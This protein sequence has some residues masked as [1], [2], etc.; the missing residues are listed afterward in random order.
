MAASSS[1]RAFTGSMWSNRPRGDLASRSDR[2][3]LPFA[4]S[5][6][7]VRGVATTSQFPSLRD[8]RTHDLVLPGVQDVEDARAGGAP[9]GG[10][11]AVLQD[12]RVAGPRDERT[13]L[14]LDLE[15]ALQH[16][17]DLVVVQVALDL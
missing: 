10:R 9:V 5:A 16:V 3:D 2:A 8:R 7:R 1:R 13:V 12:E 4:F 14:R 11:C 17:H 15:A 6:R